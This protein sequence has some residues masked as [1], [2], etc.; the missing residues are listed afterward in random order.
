MLE[1]IYQCCLNGLIQ[2][3]S[4]NRKVERNKRRQQFLDWF[5]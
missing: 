3:I 2:A 4:N 5:N 1:S